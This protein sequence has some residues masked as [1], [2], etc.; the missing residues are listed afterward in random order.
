MLGMPISH[1]APFSDIGMAYKQIAQAVL[2][3]STAQYAR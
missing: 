1:V 2:D 3:H